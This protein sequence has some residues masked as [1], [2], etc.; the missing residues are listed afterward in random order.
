MI[1]YKNAYIYI[2]EVSKYNM[3][4]WRLRVQI[5]F[6]CFLH[7]SAIHHWSLKYSR[8]KA[9]NHMPITIYRWYNIYKLDKYV[10]LFIWSWAVT[11]N[12]SR[13]I[14]MKITHN[15]GF[16]LYIQAIILYTELASYLTAHGL[17][18]NGKDNREWKKCEWS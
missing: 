2:V 1:I 4:L 5:I 13:K 10:T 17:F 9:K 14:K 8:R 12:K 16:L 3:P 11:W 15:P 6:Q 7:Q 18:A